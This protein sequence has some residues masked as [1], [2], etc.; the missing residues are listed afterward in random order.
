MT[1]NYRK[2]FT[3]IELLVVIAII[4]IL[5]SVVLASLNTA[6]DKGRDAAVKSSMQT[7]R[8]QSELY[9]E[10][11]GGTYQPATAS[12]GTC[13]GQTAANNLFGEATIASAIT[14]IT[15]QAD[16][17]TAECFSGDQAWAMSA[18][19]HDPVGANGNED[20]CTDSTGV[21]KE[22]ADGALAG[23]SCP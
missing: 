16:G 22:I 14:E 11:E 19:L 5:S 8:V 7:I 9:Y 2:G 15:S 3:L 4:G 17:G 12:A 18:S 10:D 1:I 20:W 21:A 13:S 23:T 6:R